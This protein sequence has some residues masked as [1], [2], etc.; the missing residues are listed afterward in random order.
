MGRSIQSCDKMSIWQN[1]LSVTVK[2]EK[3]RRIRKPNKMTKY[4]LIFFLG[5]GG[6]NFNFTSIYKSKNRSRISFDYSTKQT[7]L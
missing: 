2:V 4:E 7:T 1:T 6:R 3:F 5:G